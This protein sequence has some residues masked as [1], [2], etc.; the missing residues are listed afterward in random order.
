MYEHTTEHGVTVHK[1]ILSPGVSGA[2]L[3]DYTRELIEK[4]ERDKGLDLEWFAVTH[5]NTDHKHAHVVI[6]GRDK[7]GRPVRFDREDYK[8][9]RNY[10]DE[11]LNREHR[12]ERYLDREMHDL[13]RDRNY[14]RGGDQA[15]RSLIYGDRSEDAKDRGKE[16]EKRGE[17]EREHELFDKQLRD[18]LEHQSSDRPVRGQQHIREQAGRLAEHHGHYTSAMAIRRLEEIARDEPERAQDIR[19]ELE[20]LREISRDNR[21]GQRMDDGVSILLGFDHSR[22]ERQREM[23]MELTAD[24]IGGSQE[25]M[26]QQ[27]ERKREDDEQDRGSDR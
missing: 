17:D 13:M 10:G 23:E 9:L 15:F 21:A 6:L 18:S 26:E 7:T 1:F 19:E 5:E 4:I 24:G 11:Y 27:K 22:T 25:R 3:K 16:R 2:D 20:H 12:L 8:R 14:H